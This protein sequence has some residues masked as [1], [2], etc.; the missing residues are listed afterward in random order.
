M[1]TATEPSARPALMA[2][3]AGAATPR[4]R[5]R[6]LLPVGI[7]FTWLG[8]LVF[9]SLFVQWLPL[10]S[11]TTP[12]GTYNTGPNWSA[13]FLG[14][15]G[16]GRSTL[17]RIAYG[18]RVSLGIGLS[19]TLIAMTVGGLLGLATVYFGRWLTEIVDTLTN[20]VLAVP[21]LLLL[22]AIVLA[23]RPTMPVLVGALSLVFI[24]A[25]LRLT[26]VNARVQM[27]REY[28][29]QARLM[30]AGGLRLIFRE[31]VPNTIPPILSYA[32]I[33]LPSI[34]IT[35][36]SLSYLGYGVQPPTPS[37]GAMI[38]Q[39]QPQLAVAPWP[40]IIPCLVLFATVFSL[41]I[42]GDWMRVRADVR[43]AQL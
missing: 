10:H 39:A 38:A 18:S 6:K 13:E 5:R 31:V 21:P 16:I 11:P 40:A 1:T 32:A 15:D 17:S 19:A 43:E 25:F 24:P 42:V 22:L 7:A 26:R 30:G 2:V 14:F 35:E 41:N 37:W 33:V 28:V 3:L 20:I 9:L 34:I 29:L 4:R 8:V 36:G 12:A 27:N 23:L